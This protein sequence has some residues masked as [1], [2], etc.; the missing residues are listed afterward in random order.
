MIKESMYESFTGNC[1]DDNQQCGEWA[2]HGFCKDA[3][4]TGYMLVSCKKSCGVCSSCGNGFETTT[5]T[6]SPTTSSPG[7]TVTPF[8]G[9]LSKYP[10]NYNFVLS[11]YIQYWSL[12]NRITDG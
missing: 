12:A 10:Y 8:P 5:E 2:S 3:A 6:P 1:V 9:N 4:H 11:T 7:K